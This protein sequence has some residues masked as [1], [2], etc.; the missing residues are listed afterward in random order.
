MLIHNGKTY[1]RVSDIIKPFGNFSGIDENV[2]KRKAAIGTKVHDAIADDIKGDFPVT[3]P[4]TIGYFESFEKWRTALAPV[5]VESEMRYYDDTKMLTG[6]IDCLV[7][8]H[9]EKEAVLV[10]F[11]TSVQESPITWPMQAHLYHHLLAGAGK[12]IAGRYLFIKL[13]KTGKLPTVFTYK[14]DLNTLRK[15]M[16]AIDDFWKKVDIIP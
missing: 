7:K 14:F 10:D 2:L 8:L 6:C 16:Q 5:F 4:E 1:A 9:G 13:D 12:P 15:C 11:K 3:S